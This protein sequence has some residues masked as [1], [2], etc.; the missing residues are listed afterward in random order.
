[1]GTKCCRSSVVEEEGELDT[2]DTNKYIEG[3]KAEEV[4][5]I[6]PSQ[7]ILENSGV[8]KEDYTIETKLGEGSS[9]RVPAHRRIRDG[10][11]GDPQKDWRASCHQVDQ[12]GQRSRRLR[13]KAAARD[14]DSA[15]PRIPREQAIFRTT[16]TS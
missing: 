16:R 7:F 6:H 1:M 14:R 3:I 9:S 11:Q 4:L 12:S 10:V 8:V 5:T 2:I 15:P 13:G